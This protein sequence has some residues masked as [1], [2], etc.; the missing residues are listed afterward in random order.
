MINCPTVCLEAFTPA[1]TLSPGMTDET[2]VEWHQWGADAFA[3]A[4]ARDV[5]VLLSLTAVW[6]EGCSEMDAHTYSE[7]RLA[8]NINDGFVPVRVDVDRHPRVR[9][10]YNMGGFPTTA[11]LAPDG[12]L[13]TGAGYLEPDEMRQ[14]LEAVR[15]TWTDRGQEAARVPRSLTADLPPDGEVTTDIEQ[16]LAG[17]LESKYDERHDGWGADAK[18]PLPKTI[19]FAL[20]RDRSRALRT[21]DAIREQLFDSV[22]GGFFRYA[23][24]REWTDVAYEKTLTVN[25]SLIR[26]FADAYLY[27]GDERYLEPARESLSFLKTKLQ[28]EGALGGSVGPGAGAAY[29][30]GDTDARAGEDSRRVDR[31]VYAGENALAAEAL[32]TLAAYTDDDTAR[33]T[34]D[35][36]CQTLAEEAIE[37]GLVTRFQAADETG[38]QGL[39]TDSARVVTGFTTAHQVA[40]EGLEIARSIA[41][42]AIDRRYDD[43]SFRDGAPEGPGLLDRP[44]RPL[45]G[46][47][48]MA[49]GLFE[50]GVLT[51][52]DRYRDIAEQ[53]LASFAGARDRIGVQVAAYGS[54]TARL[55][56][57][58]LVIAVGDAVGSDLHRA[59]CR[60]ADHEKLVIPNAADAPPRPE[61]NVTPGEAIV[62][63]HA[64]VA[65]ATSPGEL[66][67][68]VATTTE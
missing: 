64:D 53:T 58:P 60:V 59:A 15:D 49:R 44:L 35:D 34:A 67:Q 27:T 22:E 7:P 43:G 66:M 12:R 29:Y 57:D 50:L 36:I 5:P 32:Y 6:C 21:L 45:D 9:E 65:P 8:A 68:R 23:A 42:T 33:T 13:L 25:A 62:V 37:D 56:R 28:T 10:R 38:E 30:S 16:H 61:L 18:F 14:A 47:V 2:R 48:A 19:S 3:E 41:D 11:F 51:G 54:L 52:T 20:K 55:L 39:L 4:D 24:T 17:Q 46:N 31:T 63:G 26:V 1:A 40:G